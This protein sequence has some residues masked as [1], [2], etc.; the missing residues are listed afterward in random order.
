MNCSVFSPKCIEP[1]GKINAFSSKIQYCWTFHSTLIELNNFCS[2]NAKYERK[3]NLNQRKSWLP[4][5]YRYSSNLFNSRTILDCTVQ[6][7]WQFQDCYN[8][9]P[10]KRRIY[11]RECLA[12]PFPH[13]RAIFNPTHPSIYTSLYVHTDN[14]WPFNIIGSITPASRHILPL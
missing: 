10:W 14:L 6:V 2:I 3:F 5:W 4:I 9:L 8:W 13:F 12:I 11:T 1:S 7:K